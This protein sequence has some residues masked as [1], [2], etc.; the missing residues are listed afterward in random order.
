MITPINR[1]SNNIPIYNPKGRYCVNK[2][3]THEGLNYQNITGG[4]GTPSA[5]IDWKKQFVE[6]FNK[7]LQ[8]DGTSTIT[9]PTGYSGTLFNMTS[10]KWGDYTVV[11]TTLT[12]NPT[13][14]STDDMLQFTSN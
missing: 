12:I 5:E 11:G 9:V 13:T 2:I 1:F 14:A 4:N 6:Q 10:G 3:V 8:W 7:I